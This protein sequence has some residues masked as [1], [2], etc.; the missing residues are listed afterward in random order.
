M[1]KWVR[2][3]IHSTLSVTFSS[4]LASLET[5]FTVS[6]QPNRACG[7]AMM[8]SR[9]CEVKDVTATVAKGVPCAQSFAW[10]LSFCFNSHSDFLG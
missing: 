7:L 2:M 6:T 5:K 9:L 8:C 10:I 1:V 3:K 4:E